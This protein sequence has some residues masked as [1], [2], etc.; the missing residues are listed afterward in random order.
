MNKLFFSSS[1]VA[2]TATTSSRRS[3]AGNVVGFYGGG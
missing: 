2:H 3:E 1:A